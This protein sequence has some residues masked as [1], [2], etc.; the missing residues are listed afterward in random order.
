MDYHCKSL[1][2]D[3][4]ANI[5]GRADNDN[6]ITADNELRIEFTTDWDTTHKGFRALIHIWENT[7]SPRPNTTHHW[8]TRTTPINPWTTS[9]GPRPSTPVPTPIHSQCF[10][11]YTLADCT[12]R[13]N[14]FTTESAEDAAHCQRICTEVYPDHCNYFVY[15]G[16]CKL[17]SRPSYTAYYEACLAHYGPSDNM[18]AA[19]CSQMDLFVEEHSCEVG[20]G[21][22]NQVYYEIK[23][24][25]HVFRPSE[26]LIV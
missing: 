3:Y 21:G 6:Y 15:D 8:S 19:Y 10:D 5:S 24:I 9:R 7:T 17:M 18:N 4:I 12:L 1:Y 20:K 14:E 23:L 2:W 13:H 26:R 11:Q 22:L 25:F 16:T